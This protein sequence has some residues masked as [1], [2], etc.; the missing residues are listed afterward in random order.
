[1]LQPR[2]DPGL[3]L[4]ASGQRRAAPE[5]LLDRD[6]AADAEV[7]GGEDA[8]HTAAGDLEAD[9]VAGRIDLGQRQQ[10]AGGVT[11]RGQGVGDRAA[12]RA[13]RQMAGQQLAGGAPE[14]AVGAGGEQR[15]EARAVVVVG[16]G[17][18]G[19]GALVDQLEDEP[20]RR[21]AVEVTGELDRQRPGLE[22]GEVGAL[23]HDVALC[24][25]R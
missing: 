18:S 3:A 10:I 4:E 23:G 19:T 11:G 16:A 5:Q 15:L 6:R 21:A 2:G 13:G 8:T 25:S 17:R 14:A 7:A 20:A 1:V 24:G 12:A 9:L 22:R